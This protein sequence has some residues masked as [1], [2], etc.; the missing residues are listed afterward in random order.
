MYISCDSSSE[1]EAVISVD[2][3]NALQEQKVQTIGQILVVILVPLNFQYLV[4]ASI[5]LPKCFL[6]ELFAISR[7]VNRIKTIMKI[8]V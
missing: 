1:F 4:Q 8:S 2:T 6:Y 7:G 5:E 3:A